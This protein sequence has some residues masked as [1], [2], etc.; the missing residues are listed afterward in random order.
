MYTLA[1]AE[2]YPITVNA[3]DLAWS[4]DGLNKLSVQF[5]YKHFIESD[6]PPAGRGARLNS[7]G[8]SLTI[9]GLP[10][11]DDAFEGLGLPRFGEIFNIP[12]FDTESF[13]LTGA[14]DFKSIF[15]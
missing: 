13:T 8:A 11:I 12:I 10:S 9:N 7:A 4:A 14:S 6:E 3:L 2:A 15:N 1:L 5:T